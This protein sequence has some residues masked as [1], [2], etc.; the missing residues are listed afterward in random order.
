MN[1]LRVLPG[2]W[3]RLSFLICVACSISACATLLPDPPNADKYSD[4]QLKDFKEKIA[5][6]AK[7]SQEDPR[8]NRIPLDSTEDQKS[9]LEIALEYW[10]GDMDRDQFISEGNR[11]FPGHQYEFN[12][13][14]DHLR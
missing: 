4:E 3:L 11:R 9:F 2:Q 5:E 8:Y 10:T 14:A 6:I 13:V 1:S 12:V 7:I